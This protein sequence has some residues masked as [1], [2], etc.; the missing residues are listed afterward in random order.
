VQ[1]FSAARM[2]EQVTALYET[3]LARRRAAGPAAAPK[4]AR[5]QD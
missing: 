2:V 3:A 4:R 1:H 5:A